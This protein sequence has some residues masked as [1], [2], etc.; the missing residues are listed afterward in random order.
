M[1][2]RKIKRRGNY[3]DKYIDI[4]AK[5]RFP[6]LAEVIFSPESAR[7]ELEKILPHYNAC[8]AAAITQQYN[9]YF[10]WYENITMPNNKL[11]APIVDTAEDSITHLPT[12]TFP[13]FEPIVPSDN[14]YKLSEDEGLIKLGYYCANKGM[15]FSDVADFVMFTKEMC[16]DYDLN[17]DDILGNLSNIGWNEEFGLRII[18][19]GL[20]K[21]QI[22][23]F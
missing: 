3:I 17:E 19:Y 18:D 22:I 1:S 2:C 9:E 6:S 20:G 21:N 5:E 15:E 13:Y 7:K 23:F 14:F 11:L 10:V 12:L 16:A 4:P 8:E